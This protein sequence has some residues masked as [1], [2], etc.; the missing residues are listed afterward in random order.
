MDRLVATVNGL[1]ASSVFTLPCSQ[2]AGTATSEQCGLLLA[3]CSHML[4]H[5]QSPD[6]LPI[7]P[8][9]HT[10]AYRDPCA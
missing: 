5:E 10:Y 9:V 3:G 2:L 1:D 6:Q 8:C 7:C 4:E